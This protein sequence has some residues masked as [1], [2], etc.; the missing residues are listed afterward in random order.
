MTSRGQ[1][2]IDSYDSVFESFEMNRINAAQLPTDR[3]SPQ[4]TS[5]SLPAGF[6]F[7]GFYAECFVTS[8]NKN[9]GRIC[10]SNFGIYK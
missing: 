8:A 5:I 1:L 6:T 3:Y 9:K 4:T 7:V 2:A 10:L